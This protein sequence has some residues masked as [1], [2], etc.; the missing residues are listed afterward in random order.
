MAPGCEL[1]I[2]I[3]GGPQDLSG[4]RLVSEDIDKYSTYFDFIEIEEKRFFI[5]K[6]K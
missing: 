4:L 6:A 2:S 3:L 5:I 1:G